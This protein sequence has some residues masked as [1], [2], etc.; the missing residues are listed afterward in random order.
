[1]EPM[2]G[3]LKFGGM[4][5]LLLLISGSAPMPNTAAP[6]DALNTIR[7]NF[8]LPE[9]GVLVLHDGVIRQS[10]SGV[11][12]WGDPTPGQVTDRF[13]LGSCTKAMTATVL[14]LFVE[15]GQLR[16]NATLAELFP[17]LRAT[18]NE[19]YRS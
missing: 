18:M 4:G 19:K 17:E 3:I 13:H 2:N 14:A 9:L 10:V 5:L 12:K 15:R 11:R 7:E 6:Q 1:M 16:W 8:H